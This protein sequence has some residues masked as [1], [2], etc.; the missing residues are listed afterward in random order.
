METGLVIAFVTLSTT[1]KN[2]GLFPAGLAAALRPE[3]IVYAFVLALVRATSL[4]KLLPAL[5]IS[6]LPA[7]VVAAVR[8]TYFG[9][10]YPLAAVAKPA[11]L[12]AGLFYSAQALLLSGPFWFWLGPGWGRLERSERGLAVAIIGHLA[13]VALAGGDWM[14]LLRLVAPVLP[15][16]LRVAALLIPGRRWTWQI[17]TWVCAVAATAFLG[18]RTGLPGKHILYQR[19]TLIDAAI[20]LLK[21]AKVV[22]TLDVGWVGIAH[23]GTVVDFAGVT[24]PHVAHLPGGH[25]TKRIDAALLR[26]RDVDH[27]VLLLA[28]E[29]SIST[30]WETSHFA[31]MVEGR[32][33]RYAAEMGCTVEGTLPLFD[34]RQSYL[35]VR[36]PLTT[37]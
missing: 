12:S 35:F 5:L 26:S 37:N 25:T 23:T 24:C 20:P 6:L 3:L 22:A 17:P 9:V 2:W 18:L 7:V 14:V 15:G 28:P 19:M 4:R 33:A 31:R 36:C 32:A 30:P 13:A 8:T 1:R 11:D 29:A 27:L 34:T 10:A 21:D 16:A